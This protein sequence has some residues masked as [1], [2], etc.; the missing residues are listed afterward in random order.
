[1]VQIKEMLKQDAVNAYGSISALARAT[2]YSRAAVQ[3]W[4]EVLTVKVS[5]ALDKA[6]E[7]TGIVIPRS[8]K[9]RRAA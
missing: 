2:G 8:G 4:P 3:K 6:S 7:A 5:F 1:M 9:F